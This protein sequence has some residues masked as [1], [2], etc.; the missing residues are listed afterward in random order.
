MKKENMCKCVKTVLI[1]V[2]QSHKHVF[3]FHD[4]TNFSF[5]PFEYVEFLYFYMS[6]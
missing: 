5:G 6:R 3:A 2:L 4:L 1:Y